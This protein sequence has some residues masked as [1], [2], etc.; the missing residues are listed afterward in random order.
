[1]DEAN[2]VEVTVTLAP[3]GTTGVQLSGT[4]RPGDVLRAVASA[5]ER[6]AASI[7][8]EQEPIVCVT[9]GGSPAG[10]RA[11]PSGTW[12]LLPCG[13]GLPAAGR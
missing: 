13:H 1:M 7:E 6:L 3:D 12:E 5:L 10:I 11:A 9:C 2:A 8:R 4:D